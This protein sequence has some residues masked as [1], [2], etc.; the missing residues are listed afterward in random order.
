MHG[1]RWPALLLLCAVPLF[2]T[3]QEVPTLFA[4]GAVSGPGDEGAAALT[5]DGSTVYFM[6]DTGDGWTLLESRR[7]AGGW[8]APR[9]APFSGRWHDLDPAMAPDGS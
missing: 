5:P 9:P 7:I 8:S 3:A 2:A 6:R 4:P 1:P